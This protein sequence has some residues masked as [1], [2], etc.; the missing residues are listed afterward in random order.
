MIHGFLGRDLALAHQLVDERVVVGQAHELPC[1]QAI[2]AAVP[3]V[4]DR[5]LLGRDVHRGQRR[6]HARVLGVRVGEL[7][8]A[9][10]RLAGPL[11]EAALGC[12]G[13]AQSLFEDVHGEPRG[14]L[15][16]LR[17]AHPVGDHEQRWAGQQRILVRTALTTGVGGGVLFGYAQHRLASLTVAVRIAA[18]AVRSRADA[19]AVVVRRIWLAACTG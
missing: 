2:G 15:A 10:V 13:V 8:D 11:R 7:V 6:A 14:D 4:G 5:D 17:A 18:D 19:C 16:R 3:D 9:G 1:A 12:G